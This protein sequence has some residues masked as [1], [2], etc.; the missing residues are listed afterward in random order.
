MSECPRKCPPC[1]KTT[2]KEYALSFDCWDNCDVVAWQCIYCG[3]ICEVIE[4]GKAHKIVTSG[5]DRIVLAPG[6][7]EKLK[8]YETK[9]QRA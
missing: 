1:G 9:R 5:V 7:L 3:T 6:E 2:F 8:C 4:V